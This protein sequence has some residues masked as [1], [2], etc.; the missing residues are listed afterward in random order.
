LTEALTECG[1]AFTEAAG[2]EVRFNFGPSNALARQ[3]I[4]GAPVDIFVSA[5][6]AQM[7]VAVRA[8]AILP[9][10]V[11]TIAT[12]TLVIVVPGSRARSW[13]NP[14]PL[15]GAQVRRI[16]TG[17]PN[18]VPAGVYAKVWLQR[19]GM[20]NA[21]RD[22]IVP[23]GSVRGALAAV[24]SGAADAGIVYR[25]DVR[26]L[27]EVT[28]VFDVTGRDAPDIEYPAGIVTR[29]TRSAGATR[30]IEFL[31]TPAAR[32]ILQRHGFGPLSALTLR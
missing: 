24:R 11:R 10:S 19:I 30:F 18:A 1:S 7:E 22:K 26:A 20:W 5:D 13:D 15:A 4:Q 31:R 12:N 32:R 21:V 2:I 3:I 8:G 14:S 16:A 23:T 27:R 28:V 17:D 9:G 29:S 6:A 25:T